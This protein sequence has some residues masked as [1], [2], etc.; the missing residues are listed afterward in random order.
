MNLDK[1]KLLEL[2]PVVYRLRDAGSGALEGLLTVIAEQAEVLQENLAQLY[3]DLFIETC[4]DW[5]VPYIGDLIGFRPLHQAKAG[6]ISSRAEVANTIAYRRRKGTASMLE[7]LARDV[8]GWDARVVEFFQILKTTQYLNHLR[9][10]NLASPDLRQ[11]EPLENLDTAFDS[12]AH[13]V[14]IRR[15]TRNRGRH[16]LPNIGIFLWRLA[17]QPLN[18]ADAFKLDDQRYL[19]NPLGCNVPLFTRPEAE[20]EIT[21]LAEPLNVPLAISRRRLNH[22]LD[23]YYGPD[24]SFFVENFVDK[25]FIKIC[26][27]SDIA[28]NAWAH[29][30]PPGHLAIDPELGR[31]AFGDVQNPPKVM[32][33]YGFSGSL[34]GGEYSRASTFNGE[35]KPVVKVPENYPAIQDAIDSLQGTGVVEIHQSSTYEETL[36]IQMGADREMEIRAAEGCRPVLKLEKELLISGGKDATLSLN[37]LVIS[38]ARL[39]VSGDFHLIRLSHCTL[40]PGINLKT[41]GTPQQPEEPSLI[42][43]SPHTKLEIQHSIVGGLRIAEGAQV[44]VAN[45]IV[46]A[47]AAANIAYAGINLPNPE[48]VPGAA[49]TLVNSTII[50]KVHTEQFELVSNTILL[51]EAGTWSQPVMAGKVQEGCVRFSYLPFDSKVPRRYYCQPARAED[52]SRVRPLFTSLR[53]GDPGY[54]QL[55]ARCAVEIRQGADDESEMGVWHDLYQPQRE[56]NLRVRLDEYL[57]CSLE[58]GILYA[59]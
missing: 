40:V 14:D 19:F 6:Q 24:K 39:E 30:P 38:G 58:A 41:D 46:D 18:R 1:Q 13:T 48:T 44:Q 55:S 50:G 32:Y 21:H 54:C 7:Q 23:H 4:A 22:Y 33:H 53:Y 57:R 16:N 25:K 45:S 36:V 27:L 10:K 3:D 52:A 9:L 17:A 51:A 12:L 2:L 35:L 47:T 59:S 43:S 56:I 42:V 11:W 28:G 20:D 49:L 34:G 15:I 29:T 26:N 31:I 8:T 37:G 5:V